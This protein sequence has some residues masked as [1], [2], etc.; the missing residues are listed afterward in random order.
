MSHRRYRRPWSLLGGAL[1]VLLLSSSLSA[2]FTSTERSGEALYAEQCANCHGLDGRGLGKLMPPLAGADYL[3][4]N[5]P[6]L[7]C[8]VRRG[9]KGP[10]VVNGVTYNGAM[11]AFPKDKL[12]DADVANI[13]N[14]VQSAWG[15]EAATVFTV[16]EVTDARCQ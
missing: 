6:N 7:P 9:M 15:N 1:S 5:R 12:S 2:C 13:L 10:L 16:Q 4:Q 3:R 8:L 11:P 14:Y